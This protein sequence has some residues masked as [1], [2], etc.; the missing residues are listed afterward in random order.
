MKDKVFADRLQNIAPFEFNESVASVFD[1]M[2]QRSIP[3]YQEIH[4]LIMDLVV[5]Q[6]RY[7]GKIVDLGCSTGTTISMLEIVLTENRSDQEAQFVGIDTSAPMLEKA[8]EKCA[9]VRNV[10]FIHGD[11]TEYNF[12]QTEIVIL[13]YTLQ[14]LKHSER[15][16]LLKKI[17]DSLL[18]GG[19]ILLSEKIQSPQAPMQEIIT[20][21]YYDFKR[22]NGYSELEISQKRE[23][24][25]NVLVPVTPKEQLEMLDDAGFDYSEML[26]RWYNFASYIGMKKE[27]KS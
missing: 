16:G 11:M 18:P 15:I 24:L 20:D 22:R 6:Y 5:R 14:F 13:N 10:Q 26:F 9:K 27:I 4:Q 8:K 23:A 2:V 12:E 7:K 19:I 25:E 21:L 1:D 3:F 17:Y